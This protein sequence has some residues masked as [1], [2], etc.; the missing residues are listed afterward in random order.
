MA[1]TVNSAFDEF[2][3]DKVNLSPSDTS[4]ARASRDWLLGQ[5]QK[6]P[7]ASP[8]F[9]LL[10]PE[11]DIAF[12]SFARR[13][14]IRPLDDID[15]ISCIHATGAMYV[16][17]GG[18]VQITTPAQSRLAAFCHDRSHTVN[19]IKIVNRLVKAL[20]TVPQYKSAEVNRRSEA[21]VLQLT[22]YDWNFDIV[23]AFFTAPNTQGRTYYLI[24]DG[25]GHWKK[26]DPRK[27]RDRI[28]RINQKHGGHFLNVIRTLKY[29]HRR[30]TVPS[31]SS[32][33][34]ETMVA[35]YYENCRQE[36]SKWVDLEIATALRHVATAIL[37]AIEDSK[38]IQGDLNT[39]SWDQRNA[40]RARA[41]LD[42]AR[43]DEARQ[44]EK[45]D[46][47]ESAIGKWRE[48]F[49][50]DFPEFVS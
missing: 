22:S 21:A 12:G 15:Q 13:T 37:T 38:G 42:A 27:D 2:L 48:V 45:A 24:P 10:Y 50:P 16:E 19:S 7:T 36:A 9:P 30:P 34:F 29:W 41:L 40:I 25:T 31:L 3:R 28:V 44:F 46:D 26:T 11:K 33:A 20:S 18:V 43:C 14:K 5:I 1:T 49:G 17:Y 39:L 35:G 6:F 23:P 4:T 32:Y 47:H 8:D